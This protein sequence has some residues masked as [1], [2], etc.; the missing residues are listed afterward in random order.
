[1]MQSQLETEL[2]SVR[3]QFLEVL[4]DPSIYRKLKMELVSTVDAGEPYFK[5]TYFMEGDELLVFSV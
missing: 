2:V 1:M 3:I 4:N 5:A